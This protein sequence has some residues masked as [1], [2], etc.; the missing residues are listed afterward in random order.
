MRKMLEGSAFAP[1]EFRELARIFDEIV[2]APSLRSRVDRESAAKLILEIASQQE[3][4][5]PGKIYDE[6][7]SALAKRHR[8]TGPLP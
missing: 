4:F 7:M 2:E 3:F 6:A 8:E 5:D 1:H